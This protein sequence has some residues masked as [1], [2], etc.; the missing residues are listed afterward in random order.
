[1]PKYLIYIFCFAL[2]GCANQIENRINRDLAA[3]YVSIEKVYAICLDVTPVSKISD[4]GSEYVYNLSRLPP[5]PQLAVEK[6]YASRLKNILLEMQS[7]KTKDW[8][9]YNEMNAKYFAQYKEEMKVALS[10]GNYVSNYPNSSPN[11]PSSSPTSSYP[12]VQSASSPLI[13]KP[14]DEITASPIRQRTPLVDSSGNSLGSVN[15]GGGFNSHGSIYDNSGNYSGKVDMGG[16]FNSSGSVYDKNGN[17]IGKV[18]P[19]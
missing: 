5:H 13:N 1:M 4:C 16:G 18:A 19:R 12:N 14:R 6:R 7:K 15:T 2:A 9:K 10:N 17:Y 11:Y 8:S 3:A